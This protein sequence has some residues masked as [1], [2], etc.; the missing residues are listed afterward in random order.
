[1]L[2]FIIC[3]DKKQYQDKISV[4]IN[5]VMMPYNFEYKIS[6]F[7]EYNE[8]L[9]KIIKNE[10]EQ[11]VYILDIELPEIS[12]LEIASEIREEDLDSSIIFLTVHPECQNDIFYSRLLAIDFINKDKLWQ[13]RFEE[14]II[15]TIR[16]LDKKRVLSFE[17]NHNSYRLPMR[18]I[19]Y[20]EKIQDNSKCRIVMEDDSSYEINQS[21]SNLVKILGPSFY[22]SHKSCIVNIEQ[23]KKIN[24]ADS[25]ITFNNGKTVYLLSSRNK[26]G[27]R[28]YVANY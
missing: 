22:Q 6:K 2:R 10:N 19:L 24:Y 3:E 9:S 4:I 27:I 8:E 17:F 14:T 11:K 25:T 1:M 15:Y 5:K 12:G 13:D 18:K 23:I 21:I 16:S 26:K 20:I 28:E 7:T